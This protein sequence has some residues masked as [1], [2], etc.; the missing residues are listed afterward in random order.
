MLTFSL[1]YPLSFHPSTSRFHSCTRN[2]LTLSLFSTLSAV[3]LQATRLP[4]RS[5]TSSVARVL[6]TLH[7][8]PL[9]ASSSASPIRL[10]PQRTDVFLS[11]AQNHFRKLIGVNLWSSTNHPPTFC[12]LQY[13]I[14]VC[15]FFRTVCMRVWLC[16]TPPSILP[17]SS[18]P[19]SSSSST[20][21]TSWLTKSRPLTCRNTFPAS[22]VSCRCQ[23]VFVFML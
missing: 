11:S 19:P 18:T 7:K 4:T 1:C 22:Q 16:S 3:S 5:L 13:D 2:P 12:S 8:L 14:W 9:S 6:Q 23:H 21:L 20:R 15:L 10:P 17:G